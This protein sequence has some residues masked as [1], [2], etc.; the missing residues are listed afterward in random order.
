MTTIKEQVY[1]SAPIATPDEDSVFTSDEA[2]VVVRLVDYGQYANRISVQQ[3]E[4]DETV[5][6][7][8]FDT[9]PDH[10]RMATY[11]DDAD[12]E[13]PI[14]ILH[15]VAD[16]GYYVRYPPWTYNV[17]WGQLEY[18]TDAVGR[19]ERRQQQTDNPIREFF[20][21]HLT[22]RFQLITRYMA[23][24]MKSNLTGG[25]EQIQELVKNDPE[26]TTETVKM[27]IGDMELQ[28]L[29]FADETVI[30]DTFEQCGVTSDITMFDNL[31]ESDDTLNISTQYNENQNTIA[32][33]VS[34]PAS[35]RYFKLNGKPNKKCSLE[36]T[37]REE[38]PGPFVEQHLKENM[39]IEI[40]N[41]PNLTKS[42][43]DIELFETSQLLFS[44]IEQTDGLQLPPEI[45]P[46]REQTLEFISRH[47]RVEKI[48]GEE[49]V[50]EV[51]D[52]LF[53][54]RLNGVGVEVLSDIS[55]EQFTEIGLML[56]LAIQ[57]LTPQE[58]AQLEDMMAEEI[59]EE[60]DSGTDID[61]YLS[62]IGEELIQIDSEFSPY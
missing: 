43:T 55:F 37:G 7:Y 33:I 18:L 10:Y 24:N 59:R 6:T 23:A 50:L 62:S 13:I 21:E 8:E 25:S 39:G 51:T 58:K 45:I 1:N 5:S 3:R 26:A 57:R 15:C 27:A 54:E 29:P 31:S 2:S 36:F 41:T 47:L 48:I 52:Q 20:F 60:I 38:F 44:D 35:V 4:A 32:V 28:R 34:L 40:G 9:A 11:D 17:P 22:F 61:Q 53:K 16:F 49:R 12:D 42:D 56:S 19:F 14:S 46:A 30:P